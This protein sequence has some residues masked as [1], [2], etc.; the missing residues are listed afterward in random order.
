MAIYRLKY[1]YVMQDIWGIYIY[2][3]PALKAHMEYLG[4]LKYIWGAKFIT[5]YLKNIKR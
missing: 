3:S 2:N 5:P 4:M 1:S